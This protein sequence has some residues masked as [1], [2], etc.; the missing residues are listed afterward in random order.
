MSE[1]K[2]RDPKSDEN[3]E[4]RF[5]E[6]WALELAGE[7]STPHI[8]RLPIIPD[9][10]EIAELV[11]SDDPLESLAFRTLYETGMREAEFLE[12][13]KDQLADGFLNVAS[14]QVL[15]T[16]KTLRQLNELAEGAGAK[17][18]AKI[19][20]WEVAELRKRLRA[21]ARKTGLMD[22]YEPIGRKLM[23]SVLRHA[24]GVHLVENGM[25]IY[26][27]HAL[28]GYS[29]IYTS[30]RIQEMAVGACRESYERYH[31]L[32][33]V[34]AIKIGPKRRSLVASAAGFFKSMVSGLFN[35]E[36]MNL[37]MAPMMMAPPMVVP[38]EKERE[39]HKG[40]PAD[41][42]PAQM[43]TLMGAAKDDREKML[44]RLFYASAARVSST[45]EL[46]YLD[47][48][49]DERRLFLR[50]AK[51]DIDLY[52]LIDQGTADML[53]MWQGNEPI[54][55]SIFEL[56]TRQLNRLISEMGER[57]GLQAQFE[58]LGE[59]VSPHCFRHAFATH[60]YEAGM[61]LY[62][63]QKLLGHS[64]LAVTNQYIFQHF[65]R[66]QSVYRKTYKPLGDE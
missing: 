20:G 17:K 64:S 10:V 58:P 52:A 37:V 6:E 62:H 45:A 43:I 27:L 9:R 61:E 50:E 53:R 12:L 15:L 2:K 23:P 18:D 65:K 19:F 4:L 5:A 48:F 29:S 7:V 55:D 33:K 44:S 22:R 42:N 51:G 24:C 30:F 66:H 54:S 31:P 11:A 57:S 46:H 38:V 35:L 28:L 60:V 26:L 3:P 32:A 40:S 59:S 25:D 13:S 8:H 63:I 47:V 36:M 21:R 56:S 34:P 49:Y 16:P 39:P 1:D 14:R 41:L